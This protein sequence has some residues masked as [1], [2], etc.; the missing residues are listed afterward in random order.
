MTQPSNYY[1][2]LL[3]TNYEKTTA[4]INQNKY[5]SIGENTNMRSQNTLLTTQLDLGNNYPKTIPIYPRIIP[6]TQE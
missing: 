6:I 1:G 2:P 3:Q 5:F 4:K